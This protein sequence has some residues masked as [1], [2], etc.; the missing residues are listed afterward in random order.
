[1]VSKDNAYSL[2]KKSGNLPTLPAILLKLLAACDNDETPLPKIAAIINKDPILSFKVLQLVNS[3]YYGFHQSFKGIDQAVVSLGS[4]TI[5]N[6]AVT[7]SVHQVFEQ[8][9]FENIRQFDINLFWYDSLM[10]ATLAR[11][12]SQKNGFSNLD[13]AY[14][15]GL[16]LNIGQLILLS[17]FPLEYEAILAE[18]TDRRDRLTAETQMLGVN[19]CQAGSWLMQKWKMNSTIADAIQYHHEQ[20]EKIKEAFPLAQ[21]IYASNL[22]C[23]SSNNVEDSHET[24]DQLLG[25]KYTDIQEIVEGAKDE[26]E[27]AAIDLDI[28]IQKPTK[29]NESLFQ[30]PTTIPATDRSSTLEFAPPSLINEINVHEEA[31]Q[32]PFTARVKSV[33]L[34]PTFLDDLI[35]AADV[36]SIFAVCEQAMTILFNIEKVMFFLADKS[37]VILKG[38]TSPGNSLYET[39]QRLVL[40]LH[41]NSSLIIKS[42]H[43]MSITYLR[44]DSSTTNLVDQKILRALGCNTI[45]LV[46]LL[47]DK[48]PAGIILLGLPETLDSLAADESQILQMV[49]QQVWLCLQLETSK[50]QTKAE[51]D[52]ER[53]NAVS[54]TARKVAHEINNPLGIISNYLTS[55]RLRLSGDSEIQNELSIIDEEIHRIS[56]LVEQMDM[57]SKDPVYNFELTDVNAT[58]EDIIQLFQSAGLATPG[59]LICFTPDY[60]MPHIISSKD[61]IKQILINLIKN[62]TE[63]MKNGGSITVKTRELTEA[64]TAGREGVEITVADTG[65]GLPES[66][67]TNLYR[68]F[69]TTN[70]NGHSG[71]GLSIIHKTVTVLSGT[72]SLS[73]NPTDGTSFSI[74]LPCSPSQEQTII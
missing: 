66:V 12:I 51:L 52:A 45:L 11:R 56:T 25:L 57:F 31:L 69:V 6:I 40:T 22:L 61:A 37:N 38:S 49:V 59:V 55:M 47:T 36:E 4:V 71:L 43:D 48:K 28:K 35:Q 29:A 1:M 74:F 14:L 10:C 68:P 67:M 26:V 33:S 9:R 24:L 63:A 42:Y 50:E 23:E 72:I 64:V 34:L 44:D 16:L 62:A 7:M 18:T 30:S 46:P 54:M 17:T 32:K 27:Q 2:I 60:D 5:K 53:M 15:A 39:S 65:P 19:H 41:Q 70:K 13:E 3:A 8:R 73:S 20:L 58:I 21:I